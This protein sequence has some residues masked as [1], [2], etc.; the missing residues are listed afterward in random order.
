MWVGA[1]EMVEP[2]I[3][4]GAKTVFFHHQIPKANTG[5]DTEGKD[6]KYFLNE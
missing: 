4:L 2:E 6:N 5:P 1:K 3:A